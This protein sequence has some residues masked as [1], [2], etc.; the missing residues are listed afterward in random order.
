MLCRLDASYE[1]DMTGKGSTDEMIVVKTD[2][3]EC[4]FALLKLS[5][6]DSLL[7]KVGYDLASATV[8]SKLQARVIGRWSAAP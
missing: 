1:D 2:A 4:I 7:Y 8:I 3:S 6:P 5:G